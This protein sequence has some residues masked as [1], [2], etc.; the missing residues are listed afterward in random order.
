MQKCC[1]GGAVRIRDCLLGPGR[2]LAG[3]SSR[4]MPRKTRMTIPSTAR[5]NAKT[6]RISNIRPR[7]SN[8]R[9]RGARCKQKRCAPRSNYR[10]VFYYLPF[11]LDFGAGAF[12]SL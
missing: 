8:I 12:G 10:S 4:A 11:L 7:N 5:I 6:R 9:K 2:R 1:R 3:D